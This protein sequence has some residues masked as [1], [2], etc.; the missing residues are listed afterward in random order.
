VGDF[1]VT[2][3]RLDA[4][5]TDCAA[6]EGAKRASQERT[7]QACITCET[8]WVAWFKT[9]LPNREIDFGIQ[10]R[11]GYGDPRCHFVLQFGRM[12]GHQP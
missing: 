9:L 8:V 6:W 1:R 5:V 4:F 7:D 10:G 2:G 11:M 3:D 12:F